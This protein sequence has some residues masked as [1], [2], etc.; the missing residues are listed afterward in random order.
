MFEVV[1]PGGL[2]CAEGDAQWSLWVELRTHGLKD[3]RV[4]FDFPIEGS[5]LF[6]GTS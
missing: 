5:S 4:W 2:L 6:R 1:D 3:N